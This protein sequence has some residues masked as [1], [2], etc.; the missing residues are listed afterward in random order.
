MGWEG[1]E[2]KEGRDVVR[3]GEGGSEEE[4]SS[5]CL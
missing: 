1:E 4:T 2:G 3:R 5:E